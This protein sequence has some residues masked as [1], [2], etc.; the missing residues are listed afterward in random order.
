MTAFTT[1]RPWND[2][3]TAGSATSTSCGFWRR[4]IAVI[5]LATWSL[6]APAETVP[7]RHQSNEPERRLYTVGYAHLDTQ[8][9]WGYPRVI[10]RYIP[11]T[12]WDNFMLFEEHPNYIFNFTGGNRYRFMQEYYPKGFEELRHW[13]KK[14]RWFPAGSSW[15][16]GDVN[17]PSTESVIRHVLY[18]QRYFEREFGTES[19]EYM[20]PDCFG[21]PA[22]LPSVLAHCG[23]RGFSTQKLSW[24]SAVGIPFN[25]GVWEGLDGESVIAALNPGAYDADVKEN[26][27]FST[28]WKERIEANGKQSGVYADYHYYGVGDE[29]GAPKESSVQWIEQALTSTGT[30]R[31]LSTRADQLFRDI[32][33]EQ[34]ARLPRY[35]GDLLLTEHSA[36]SLTSQ[37][38]MKRWN[39]MNE[40][41]AEAA[42]KA[43]VA[44][45]LVGGATYPREKIN[46]AWH[47]FL[48]SQMHDMLPGTC[49]PKAYE[50]CWNDEL[51]A[52]NS[53]ASV[54]EDAVGGVAR[55][56]DTQVDGVPLVVFNPLSIDREDLVEAEVELPAGTATARVFTANGAPLPTQTLAVSGNSHRVLFRGKVPSIGFAVF[57]VRGV[58]ARTT[59]GTGPL[60]VTD[61]TL[62]NTRYRVA[63]N[64]AGD[65]ASV[66]DKLAN[67][68][69]LVSPAR[70][71]FLTENPREWP[72]WNMDW[73]DRTNAPRNYVSGPAK[74]R[75]VETGQVRVAIE[76]ERESE[77]S[78]F[79]Q[80]IRLAAGEAG[81]RVEVMNRIAWQ[82]KACSLK[83]EFP[84][85]VSN[86]QATY[87][88]E[89]GKIVRGN[90]DPKKY[91]VPSR[92]WFDLTDAN[93]DYGVTV[94]APDKYGSDKPNDH[95]L[96]LTLLY[97][98]GVSTN[99]GY[100]E[101]KHQDWGRHDIVYGLSGH[102][103]DWRKGKSDWE[104]ARLGQPMLAFQTIAHAG[105]LGRTFSLLKTDSD[106][107]AVRTVKLAEDNDQIV[108]RL[109]ELNGAAAQK[110]TIA[111]G[112]ALKKA[113]EVNG[114]ERSPRP[115]KASIGSLSLD[116][117]PFQLRSLALSVQPPA[118][119]PAMVSLPLKLPFN[120]DAFSF[121]ELKQDGAFD[122]D[123]ATIPAEMIGD[124]VVAEGIKFNIGSRANRHRN[125]VLCRGQT[126][127]LPPGNFDRLYL[128]A[129]S[130]YGDVEGEFKVGDCATTLSV[131]DWSGY[132]GSWD[133]R[134]FVGTV[135]ERTF[136]VNNP[137]DSIAAGYIKR[138]PL[139]WFCTHRHQRTGADE[140][141]KYSYL[142]KYALPIPSGA[143]ALTLPD[144]P[145]IRV[146]AAT[147]TRNDNGDTRTARP[148][149]DDFTGRE[150][151]ELR[152]DR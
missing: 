115:V 70:L 120:I 109:Q 125:A 65:I 20:L 118:K 3:A 133:N 99:G 69:L 27:S 76:V 81:N 100:Q 90:N 48:G 124:T 80:T 72:A 142:F 130:I 134:I 58:G 129:C 87:N 110:V 141:Y 25:I 107:V 21:F 105:K 29:G 35:K 148:L 34:K 6:A 88:W 122:V 97:S 96:R 140:V 101:Q 14:G 36:G 78:A 128:L 37:S 123:G 47:L 60:K 119:L 42:E 2:V 55:A 49:L 95:T 7:T 59:D 5:S 26:L 18:G 126:I 137:L 40:M 75:V 56:L 61:R 50:Y 116:F 4:S 93:G 43:S 8:W 147:A 9:R 127:A 98:P 16:E 10:S 24:G 46:R 135:P 67:R 13:V 45:H 63:L 113:T 31:V 54:L 112:S 64:D 73:K 83:A 28:K 139:A 91:E 66:H 143:K 114:I 138:D 11:N 92:Q 149:Y 74:I 145:R 94:L 151:I 30:V 84:L 104:A 111:T 150:P 12:M 23:L 19:C 85:T 33:D 41:L 15:D 17:V 106:Q 144:N 57:A 71:A 132:I 77:G 103:G 52:L 82:S 121:N 32:T 79:V 146:F 22:S 136:S 53:F 131:Q 38:Y 44:A 89:L 117:K 108:V 86:P 39:R 152:A 68:E 51:I 1:R 102:M 62:E